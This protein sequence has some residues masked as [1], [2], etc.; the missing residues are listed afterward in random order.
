LHAK[1]GTKLLIVHIPKLERWGNVLPAFYCGL[2][3]T[4]LKVPCHMQAQVEFLFLLVTTQILQKL[5]RRPL[6]MDL[7]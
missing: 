6:G 4:N 3:Y 5:L 7:N 1:C 2:K